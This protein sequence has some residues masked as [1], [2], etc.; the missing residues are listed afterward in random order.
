MR[1][2][3]MTL[4]CMPIALWSFESVDAKMECSSI[5]MQKESFDKDGY[6]WLKGFY[7]QEQVKLIRG[8][9]DMIDQASQEL[10]E[11][12]KQSNFSLQFLAKHISGALIVVPE[13]TNPSRACR[14]EDFL[15]CYPDLSQFVMG[16]VTAYIS[17]MQGE[18]YTIFK[19]KINFKWP[20]G[21]AFPPHQDFPAY[22]FLGPRQHIT[23]MICIDE[24]TQENGCLYVASQWQEELIG[25]EGVDEQQLANGHI[26]LPFI[27]GGK[28]H[29][30]IKP[31]LCKKMYWIPIEA[32]PGDVLLFNSFVPHFSHPN[33]SDKPRRAM[34]ITHNRLIEG[35]FRQAYFFTKRSDPDNPIFHIATPTKA[36]TKE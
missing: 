2:L 25:E 23:A 6:I 14:A 1:K 4:A 17:Q 33:Q 30:S 36:R 10:I 22:E 19:D 12:S 31:E 3:L 5:E 24:A 34:F 27:T 20:L 13:A 9:A 18:P 32:K 15:S 26:V 11:L 7:S 29:G 16:T 28:D 35:D 8:W 21:G